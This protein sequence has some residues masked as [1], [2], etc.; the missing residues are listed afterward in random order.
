[1]S[2]TI[3]WILGSAGLLFSLGCL[4]GNHGLLIR[5]AVKKKTASMIPFIGGLVGAG[6]LILLPVQGARQ[7]WWVPLILDPGSLLLGVMLLLGGR[8]HCG[9]SAGR[10]GE[11]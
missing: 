10:G 7:Y 5:Y 11:P 4:V 1:M 9:R 3:C 2:E 6:A 8:R